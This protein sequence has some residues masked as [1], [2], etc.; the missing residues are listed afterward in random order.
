MDKGGRGVLEEDEGAGSRLVV[1]TSVRRRLGAGVCT[2]VCTVVSGGQA[3]TAVG[4]AEIMRAPCRDHSRP[5]LL[6]RI[7]R[8][9]KVEHVTTAPAL[10]AVGVWKARKGEVHQL[11]NL[12]KQ[13]GPGLNS[14]MHAA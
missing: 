8:H 2:G 10:V 6:K 11:G 4:C 9:V 13:R 14:R 5:H 12:Q 7:H 1:S 3:L